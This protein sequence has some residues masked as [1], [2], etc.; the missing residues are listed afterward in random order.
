MGAAI[1]L[2]TSDKVSF[3]LIF[4]WSQVDIICKV[5]RLTC[6]KGYC[7]CMRAGDWFSDAIFRGDL[8]GDFVHAGR[9]FDR[10]V[11]EFWI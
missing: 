10:W 6:M 5:E 2:E 8:V 3:D 4:D 9:K 1:G 7:N 11:E